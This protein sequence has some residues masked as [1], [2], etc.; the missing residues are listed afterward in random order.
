MNDATRRLA[1]PISTSYC[2][3]FVVVLAPSGFV[4]KRQAI[5]FKVVTKAQQHKNK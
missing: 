5:D 1:T 4:V 2:C 3:C